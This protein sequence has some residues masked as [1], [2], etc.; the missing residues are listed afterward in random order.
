MLVREISFVLATSAA[1]SLAVLSGCS[2]STQPQPPAFPTKPFTET[3][4][5]NAGGEQKAVGPGSGKL[6]V[7]SLTIAN[8]G[9]A[10]QLWIYA[11]ATDGPNCASNIIGGS[12]PSFHLILEA[13][14]TIDLEFPTP[15]I[16]SS[17]SP[18][19]IAVAKTSVASGNV[20]VLVNGYVQ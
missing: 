14:K 7:T 12:F 13:N 18:S 19:C 20:E 6:G 2:S 17:I 15:L 11:P 8:F 3:I 16:F 4:T 5:L 10:T 1:V 9:G